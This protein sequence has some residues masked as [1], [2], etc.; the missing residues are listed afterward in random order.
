MDYLKINF[1]E[2]RNGAMKTTFESLERAFKKFNI[3]YYLIGAFARDMWLNHLD[4][5]PE[6]RATLDIDFSIYINDHAQ[7]DELKKY[8]VN[9]EGFIKDEEPYRL[10]ASNQNIVD[11]IPFGG[12]E[13]DNIVYLNSNPPMELS[14]F[15]NVQVLSHASVIESADAEFKICT[16][17]GL[18]VLKLIAGYEK[19]ER[20]AKDFGDFYYIL[21]HYFDIKNDEAFDD[22]SDLIDEEFNPL[23]AGAKM[24]GR[25][26][27]PILNDSS[28]LRNKI[29]DVLES[30]QEKFSA[31]EIDQMFKHD[32]KNDK[33]KKFKMVAVLQIEI[34]TFD[35]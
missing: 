25:Q 31:I 34:K 13:K 33:I 5:L 24:L 14:V 12:I 11:L 18:C 21:E 4:Y 29:L 20:R 2:M 6:R 9:E 8:L 16:L 17:P 3:D 32:P 26:M 10:Y 15:G 7:F 1:E 28:E 19:P 22:F 27:F 23:I 30:L 35:F